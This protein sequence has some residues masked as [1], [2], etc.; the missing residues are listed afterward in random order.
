MQL[1]DKVVIVTGATGQL[2]IPV[3]ERILTEGANVVIAYREEAG[4]ERLLDR[5]ADTHEGQFLPLKANLALDGDVAD[6]VQL[7]AAAYG[8]VDA[9][10]HLAGGWAGGKP[11]HE[12]EEADW[13]RMMDMNLKSAFL[14]AKHVIPTMLEQKHGR[15][16]FI[17]SKGALD[18]PAGSSAYNVSKAGINTLVETLRKELR[19]TGVTANAVMP[20]TIDTPQNRA[21]MPKADPAKWV[22]PE[23][24]AQVLIYLISD[25]S[26]PVNGA[27]VP[28]FGGVA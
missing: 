7:T 14:C 28:V 13:D 19:G 8:R 20:S 3:T 6:L 9:L 5:I 2:G 16:V 25:A 4:L 12:M 22:T 26:A 17:S 15:V 23:D 11:V 24:I 21:A 10:V 27:I 18:A 1:Q